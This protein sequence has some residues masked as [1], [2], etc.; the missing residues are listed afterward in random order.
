MNSTTTCR[1]RL[2]ASPDAWIE[3]EA[4]RQLYAVSS[5]RGIRSTVG[6]PDLH[7]GKVMPNG[8]AA[9][10]EGFIYPHLIGGDI[11]CGMALFK[12]DLTR[13]KANP[14]QWGLLPF[15][16]ELPWEGDVHG[17]LGDR[18]LA[19][20]QFADSFGTLGGGNHFAELQAVEKVHDREAFRSLG[21]SRDNLALL[22]HSGS[23]EA[24][25]SVFE[26]HVEEHGVG[27][28]DAESNAGRDY[29][30]LHDHAVRW[31]RASREVIAR[32]FLETVGASGTSVW[33]GCHNSIVGRTVG[34]E[35]HWI[36]RK[37][38]VV[39][40]SEIAVIAG[41]RGSFSYLVKPIG[42]GESH[43]W[44]LAHGAGRK[45]ARCEARLRVRERHAVAELVETPLGGRVVCEDRDLL[46]EEAPMAF[47][48]IEF[49]I[50]ALIKAKLIRVIATLRPLF[51]YKLR[52]VRR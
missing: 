33:D 52:Q 27:A 14:D 38:A 5:L 29:L 4:V 10:A 48:S 30:L 21:M 42:D 8:A 17:F 1:T 11:G 2:I 18:G 25:Q 37:G 24:G 36:H 49:V 46:Y 13:Q 12:T 22:I 15:E 50:D 31:A 26:T 7:P 34:D 40:D 32:R 23:R 43:A 3:S 39:A 6:F 16:L 28:V 44:S 45:W 41:S 51:T 47:K 9:V 19:A 20:A 35:T